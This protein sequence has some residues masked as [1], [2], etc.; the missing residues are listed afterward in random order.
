M[1]KK[2]R[3]KSAKAKFEAK[4]SSHPRMRCLDSD[5]VPEVEAPAAAPEP[6][7]VLQEE[8]VEA[9]PEP[10]PKPKT[11]KKPKA[12]KKPRRTAKKKATKKA[13]SATT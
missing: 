7:V 4:H 1:G 3:L 10:A 13:A 9:K 8:K 5:E 11:I 12:I 2:R 6:E